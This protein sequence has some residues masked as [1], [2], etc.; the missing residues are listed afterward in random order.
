MTTNAARHKRL[1]IL[2]G[3]AVFLGTGCESKGPAQRAGENID[4]GVQIVRT[5]STRQ[6]RSKAGRAVDSVL[7]K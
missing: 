3:G 5:P 1:A 6:A 7:N 2:L 4:Q